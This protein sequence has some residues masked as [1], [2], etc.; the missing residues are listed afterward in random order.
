MQTELFPESADEQNTRDS[1]RV[2]RGH[3][4]LE[5]QSVINRRQYSAF[6][7]IQASSADR[8]VES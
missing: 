8:D 6:F 5:Y 3:H 2:G 1:L 7:S 4:L